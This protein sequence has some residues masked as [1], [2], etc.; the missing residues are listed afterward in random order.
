MTEQNDLVSWIEAKQNSSTMSA[1]EIPLA[2]VGAP[3]GMKEN[4][5]YGRSDGKFFEEVGVEITNA[6]REV[7]KWT[8]PIQKELGPVGVVALVQAETSGRV[9]IT[10]KAE[11]GNDVQGKVLAAP[12]Y[13]ASSSNFEQAHGGKK[14]PLVEILEMDDATCISSVRQPQDGGR[15][16]NKFVDVR[17]V[18]VPSEESIEPFVEGNQRWSSPEEVIDVI[19]KGL[20]NPHLRDAYLLLMTQ[21]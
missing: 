18:S 2:E 13:H 15:T 10:A 9:L 20:C 21:E 7:Q 3:W 11:P 4:G 12:S 14:P 6:G 1:R 8:Q 19:R 16:L 17:T 5:N